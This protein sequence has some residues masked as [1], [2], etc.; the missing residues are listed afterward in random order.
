MGDGN[1]GYMFMTKT[2]Y[3]S[4]CEIESPPYSHE[5]NTHDQ[6]AI[7]KTQEYG[8]PIK[9]PELPAEIWT[10]IFAFAT[11]I[12]GAFDLEDSSAI[13]GFTRDHH[14]ICINNRYQAVMGTKTAATLV[15]KYWNNIIQR[16]LFEYIRITSGAQ[17]RLAAEALRNTP[18]N[19]GKKTL[20]IDIALEGVHIWTNTH[21]NAIFQ[22]LKNCPNLVCFSTAF[23]TEEPSVHTHGALFKILACHRHLKRLEIKVDHF[24]TTMAVLERILGDRLQVLWLVPRRLPSPIKVH[25]GEGYHFPKLHTLVTLRCCEYFIRHLEVPNLRAYI[26]EQ[27][28]S[29]TLPSCD[30]GKI[31]YVRIRPE[32]PVI[33][34]LQQWTSLETFSI[35]YNELAHQVISWPMGFQHSKLQCIV[36]ENVDYGW[37]TWGTT[38][39]AASPTPSFD[40]LQENLL[41]LI[42]QERFPRLRCARI[43]LPLL[44]GVKHI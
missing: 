17:A 20:R 37:G 24:R 15:C 2:S 35:H 42:S 31:K 22:I 21:R 13:A 32:R 28:A 19:L 44:D 9:V 18:G 8:A 7:P 34:H 30:K 4:P 23:S 27:S 6:G 1:S 3:Y 39:A 10:K 26:M 38:M 33:A 29:S 11:Q 25:E 41:H 14:G 36:I 40:H 43:F 5:E 16:H 12:P